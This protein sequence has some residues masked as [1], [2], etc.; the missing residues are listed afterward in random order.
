MG[1]RIDYA[2][3]KIASFLDFTYEYYNCAGHRNRCRRSNRS[4][5]SNGSKR[6]ERLEQL[7]RLEL[8]P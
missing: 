8:I 1:I 6:L 5:A 2:C 4:N 3:H 7:E